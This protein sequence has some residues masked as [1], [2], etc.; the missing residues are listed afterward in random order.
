MRGLYFGGS[1]CDYLEDRLTD[2]CDY[3]RLPYYNSVRIIVRLIYPTA[4]SLPPVIINIIANLFTGYILQPR[5]VFTTSQTI[6]E[7]L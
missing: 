1:P 2:T 7:R 6:L 3:W 4:T 5:S